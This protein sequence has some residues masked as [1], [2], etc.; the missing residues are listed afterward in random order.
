[1]MMII[2]TRLYKFILFWLKI[3]FWLALVISLVGF[4]RIVFIAPP[5]ILIFIP[6][7]FIILL[8]FAYL[9]MIKHRDF[10][11]L[12]NRENARNGFYDDVEDVVEDDIETMEL[13]KAIKDRTL[14]W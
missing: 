12:I 1:M 10:I 7:D 5:L 9:P 3:W 13:K 11:I 6:L 2:K 4:V 8:F 14:Y